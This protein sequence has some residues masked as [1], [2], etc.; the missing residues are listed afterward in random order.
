MCGS[1]HVDLTRPHG[2]P[3]AIGIRL[4][5]IVAGAD[6]HDGRRGRR[7]LKSL[8]GSELAKTDIDGSLGDAE[9]SGLI[10]EVEDIY[11]GELVHSDGGGADV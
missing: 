3:H 6:Q 4:E 8:I 11:L 7:Y 9:L 10:V 2:D 1:G 5:A